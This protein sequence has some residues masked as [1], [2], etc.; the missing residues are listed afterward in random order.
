MQKIT[1][2]DMEAQAPNP[3]HSTTLRI[4]CFMAFVAVVGLFV[5]RVD[6]VAEAPG[7]IIP[8]SLLKVVQPPESGTI[9]EVFV[10]EGQSIKKGQV[11]AVLD[12]VIPLADLTANQLDAAE[13]SMRLKR[14]SAEVTNTVF[15]KSKEDSPILFDRHYSHYLARTQAYTSQIDQEKAGL[16]KLQADQASATQI[17]QKLQDTIPLYKKEYQ[18]LSELAQAGLKTQ[19]EVTQ[20][21][22]ELIEK[23][24]DLKSQEFVIEG[25]SAAINQSKRK[26]DQIRAEYLKELRQ[27][28]T[29]TQSKLDKI[30]QETIKQ[31]YK[32]KQ[33][34]LLAPADGI[35]KDLAAHT[36]GTVVSAG[37]II[38]TI[39]PEK[40]ELIAEVWL[41]NEDAG[42]A[43]PGQ[44]VQI[45]VA[46]YPFQKYGLI[47]GKVASISPDSSEMN[48]TT[49]TGSPA[50]SVQPTTQ[51][52]PQMSGQFKLHVTLSKTTLQAMGK[53]FEVK[54]GMQVV[55][56][57]NEGTRTVFEYFTSPVKKAVQEAA[58]ER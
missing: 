35:V 6:I 32:T 9:K 16:E 8:K 21:Q 15:T 13:L 34:E 3:L 1:L 19:F 47:S 54:P 26:L 25:L 40:E 20:K 53:S 28:Q 52:N 37:S 48:N 12:P 46:T 45:K 39:V 38:M 31:T 42:F 22:R 41:K 30:G 23:E 44:D 2:Q 36:P 11:L 24:R 29:E 5:G 33:L 57:I 51:N 50:I 10:K 7:K 17:K 55:A 4:L 56:E 27:D 58:R 49:S 43:Y 14:I 18:D